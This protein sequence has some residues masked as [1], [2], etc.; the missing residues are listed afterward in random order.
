M[1]GTNLKCSR[2][3][4]QQIKFGIFYFLVVFENLDIAISIE[5][6]LFGV[7][8]NRSYLDSIQNIREPNANK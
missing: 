8:A 5:S 6:N 3:K 7:Q 4:W 2:T 1:N